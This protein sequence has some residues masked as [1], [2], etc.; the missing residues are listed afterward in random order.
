MKMPS[1]FWECL[2]VACQPDPDTEASVGTKQTQGKHQGNHLAVGCS[3]QVPGWLT[4]ELF[5]ITHCA[6]LL[7]DLQLARAYLLQQKA[8]SCW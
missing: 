4:A 7:V 3:F 5:C 8:T 6:P 2:Q 1:L